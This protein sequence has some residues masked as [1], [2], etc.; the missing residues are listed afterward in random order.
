MGSGLENGFAGGGGL[1]LR[2]LESRASEMLEMIGLGPG[3]G[4]VVGEVMV[5]VF[6]GVGQALL[7][8]VV[9]V[10]VDGEEVMEAWLVRVGAVASG[11]R[12][13]TVRSEGRVEERDRS[14]LR[15]DL[16]RC[17]ADDVRSRLLD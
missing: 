8:V 11:L 10:L 17:G 5:W 2:R 16:R 6:R 14:E 13:E 7:A 4:A 3:M 1:C 9:E 15:E 12:D